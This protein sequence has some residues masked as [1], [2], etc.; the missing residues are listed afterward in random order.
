MQISFIMSDSVLWNSKHGV[1]KSIGFFSMK[2]GEHSVYYIA[3]Q[4]CK[5]EEH[6]D[7]MIIC[8]CHL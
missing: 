5:V 3:K 4:R 8:L 7:Y 6:W 2:C 1:L